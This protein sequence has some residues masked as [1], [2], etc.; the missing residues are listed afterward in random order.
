MYQVKRW[1]SRLYRYIF[2]RKERAYCLYLWWK[3]EDSKYKILLINEEAN[4][5]E[6]YYLK[7]IDKPIVFNKN[8]KRRTFLFASKDSSSP[9]INITSLAVFP[10]EA[11]SWASD[12]FYLNHHINSQIS[13]KIGY[14]TF[15]WRQKVRVIF[16]ILNK[17]ICL[18]RIRDLRKK[19]IVSISTYNSKKGISYLAYIYKL[20]VIS[21]FPFWFSL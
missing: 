11:V 14:R 15:L 18:I 9:C 21:V 17:Q 3:R 4:K 19:S 7:T 12:R 8:N 20:F 1:N 16:I 6:L 5:I 2:L 10:S 13:C